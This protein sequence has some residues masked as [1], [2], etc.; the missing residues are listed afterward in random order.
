MI[1]LNRRQFLKTIPA[2]ALATSLLAHPGNHSWL[3][4]QASHTAFGQTPE[5][6]RGLHFNTAGD[7]T[8]FYGVSLRKEGLDAVDSRGRHAWEME[9]LQS[10]RLSSV[11]YPP[12]SQSYLLAESEGEEL[13]AACVSALGAASSRTHAPQFSNQHLKHPNVIR[14]SLANEPPS[15]KKDFEPYGG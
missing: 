15:H 12:G 14:F 6:L 7:L 9:A 4:G 13:L 8:R 5:A 10:C 2:S 1:P 3:W 11:R